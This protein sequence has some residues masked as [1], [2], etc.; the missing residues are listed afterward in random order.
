MSDQVRLDRELEFTAFQKNLHTLLSSKGIL[1]KDLAYLAGTTP[2]TIS[3]YLTGARK[4]DLEYVYRLA[5]YFGVS[6]DWLLGLDEERKDIYTPETRRIAQ[7]YSKASKDDQL[8]I[9]TVLQK[10]DKD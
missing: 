4:P 8:V 6:I 3:R 10:Y 7:L 1:G 9:R 5:K 2:A